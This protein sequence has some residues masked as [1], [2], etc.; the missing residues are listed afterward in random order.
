MKQI[1]NSIYQ[2]ELFYI[3][4]NINPGNCMDFLM[5]LHNLSIPI[6][7]PLFHASWSESPAILG[8]L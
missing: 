6:T 1:W 3:D 8:P 4:T 2:L 7:Y 5:L